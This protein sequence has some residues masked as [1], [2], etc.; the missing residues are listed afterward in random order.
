MNLR[1]VAALV[2]LSP[3]SG[4]DAAS[5]PPTH[6]RSASTVRTD[7]GSDLR[8]PPGYFVDEPAWTVLDGEIRRLQEAE[9]RLGAENKSL[10]KSASATP[11]GWGALVLVTGAIAGGVMLGFKI[12]RAI[13][14]R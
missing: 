8:L 12:A 9:V 3:L 5:D 4:R 7:G 2:F 1:V 14:N 10:R 11:A 13:D 6:I